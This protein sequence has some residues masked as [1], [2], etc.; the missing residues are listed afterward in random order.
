M[1]MNVAHVCEVVSEV[2]AATPVPVRMAI[3]NVDVIVLAKPWK[4]IGMLDDS[5]GMYEGTFSSG[6]DDELVQEPP[7]GTIYLVASNLTDKD[8]ARAVLLHEMAHALGLDE[9]EVAGL[10]L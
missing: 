6:A 1:G 3:A 9:T 7:L 8:D 2:A 5:R 4:E 10:G